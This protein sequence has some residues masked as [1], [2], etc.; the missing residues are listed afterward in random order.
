MVKSNYA[1]LKQKETSQSWMFYH[2]TGKDAGL[3]LENG[4]EQK[5]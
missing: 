1:N 3:S 2:I 5:G 4:P